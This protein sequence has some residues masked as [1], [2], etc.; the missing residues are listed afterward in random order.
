MTVMHSLMADGQQTSVYP[1]PLSVGQL[2]ALVRGAHDIAAAG[3]SWHGWLFGWSKIDD[4]LV[5]QQPNERQQHRHT[6]VITM[7]RT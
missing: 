7:I 5:G 2:L 4:I 6:D 3:H 1:V